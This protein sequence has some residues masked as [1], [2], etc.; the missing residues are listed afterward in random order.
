MKAWK[1]FWD[2]GAVVIGLF[3]WWN[4]FIFCGKNIPMFGYIPIGVMLGLLGLGMGVLI[5]HLIEGI[6]GLV[7]YKIFGIRLDNKLLFE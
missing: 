2:L 1:L 6:I 5:T 4:I 3:F 7:I